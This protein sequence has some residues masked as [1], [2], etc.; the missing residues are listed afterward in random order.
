M[1]FNK[2][3]SPL[4]P[5]NLLVFYG[6]NYLFDYALSKGKKNYFVSNMN[7][8][9]PYHAT[10]SDRSIVGDI[11]QQDQ[12]AFFELRRTLHVDGPCFRVG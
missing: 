10:S 7:F 2:K 11:Y 12:A 4:F 6:D 8:F 9:T 1:F 3:Y 5:E